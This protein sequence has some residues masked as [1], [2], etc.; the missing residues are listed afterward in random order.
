[1]TGL[2]V[3]APRNLVGLGPG[4][5]KTALDNDV[6]ISRFRI[7]RQ[8]VGHCGASQWLGWTLVSVSG[9]MRSQLV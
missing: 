6:Q 4:G 9:P 8:L 7:D 5:R 2:P 3:A 1:M